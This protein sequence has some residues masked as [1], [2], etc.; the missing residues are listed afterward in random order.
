MKFEVGDLVRSSDSY[1]RRHKLGIITEIKEKVHIKSSGTA[2]IVMVYWFE[3][4]ES[5]WE[6]TFFLEKL[7]N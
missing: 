4:Q 3:I 2:A 7:D 5:D 1:D 6:Y